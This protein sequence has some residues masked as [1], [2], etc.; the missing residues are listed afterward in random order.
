MPSKDAN[1][2]AIAAAL[3]HER[4]APY[5]SANG[6]DLRAAVHLYEW[7]LTVSGAMYEALGVAEVVLRNAL[8]EQFTAWHGQSP[9][10]WYDDPH[11]VLSPIAH[12]DIDHARERVRR[13]G[14]PETPG[15]VVAELNFGFWKFLLAKRYETT[16]WTPCLRHAFPNLTPQ[17]RSI[18][19]DTL[20]DLHRLRNRV[21]H[22]E[23]I[24]QRNLS[25]DMLAIYRLLEWI[26]ADVRQWA[27]TL[28]R[29]QAALI[30]PR[31]PP[32]A[33]VEGA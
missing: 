17:N 19:F 6:G 27:I 30:Q 26:D 24:H 22:H 14:R 11:G 15:R 33:A 12:D 8:N 21:A 4:L 31:T 23:P 5:L 29:V 3:S 25:K 1:L 20:D 13:L 10:E 16:L 32:P 28:S 9:G 18:V 2:S 7:N